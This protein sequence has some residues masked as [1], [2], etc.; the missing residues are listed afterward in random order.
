MDYRVSPETV[1]GFALG[2]GV[3]SW[4]LSDNLGGGRSDDFDA[5]VYGATHF[6]AAYVAA[7]AAFANHWM[8]TNRTSYA[9]DALSG[10]FDAQSFGG[11]VESGYRFAT[12]L[13]GITPYGAFEAESFHMPAFSEA[14]PSGGGVGEAA[15]VWAG[16][17]SS[18]QGPT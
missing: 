5:G 17:C 1:L 18:W 16:R 6:G 14:D 13:G 7:A 2:G 3:S 8:T 12:P 15:L 9:G 10:S 11:R 4:N